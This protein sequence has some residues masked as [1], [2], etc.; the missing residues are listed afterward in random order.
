MRA[1][2]SALIAD[3]RSSSCLE[4]RM[5][6]RGPASAAAAAQGRRSVTAGEGHARSRPARVHRFGCGSPGLVPAV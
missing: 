1:N 2:R 4:F 3:L 5:A 6:L